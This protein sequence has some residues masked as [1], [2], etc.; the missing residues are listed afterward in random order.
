MERG[1]IRNL[2]LLAT[3]D[4][5]EVMNEPTMETLARRLGMGGKVLLLPFLLIGLIGCQQ[6]SDRER[7][8]T[9]LRDA[10]TRCWKTEGICVT[11]KWKATGL[12][13]KKMKDGM[14]MPEGMGKKDGME[15]PEGMG[16]KEG[17][18]MPEGMSGPEVAEIAIL[19]K[20]RNTCNPAPSWFRAKDWEMEKGEPK[21]QPDDPFSRF[22]AGVWKKNL[23]V[24]RIRAELDC[25]RV[26]VTFYKVILRD[27]H[28]L[29][30]YSIELPDIVN[31]WAA[32]EPPGVKSG[33]KDTAQAKF[34]I[35]RVYLDQI[36]DVIPSAF[37]KRI[38]VH[39]VKRGKKE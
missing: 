26:G 12:V 38:W 6:T 19:F 8:D 18:E 29:D 31:I 13:Y 32:A 35:P 3:E 36:R 37:F 25:S 10:G 39:G 11:T 28:G 34:S 22:G 23:K 5:G 20:V 16:K 14:E 9:S 21:R 2:Y 1:L 4:E 24:Y 7:I 15:I 17:M 30:L 27:A 33:I